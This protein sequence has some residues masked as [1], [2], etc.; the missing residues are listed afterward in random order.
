MQR[1]MY[2]LVIVLL[3]GLLMEAVGVVFLNRGLHQI[4]E[5]SQINFQ[6]VTRIILRGACNGN[7]LLGIFFEAMFF[8]TIL[9]LMSQAE[10]SFIW[11]MTSLGFVFTTLAA[12]LILHEEIVPMRW[13]GVLLI[14]AGAGLISWTEKDAEA[15][16]QKPL[17]PPPIVNNIMDQSK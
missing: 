10:V 14:V 5:V 1:V 12:W 4:G 2:K 11:P 17:E 13:V 3:I 16:K 8:G 9:Y 15:K 6:E 7:V